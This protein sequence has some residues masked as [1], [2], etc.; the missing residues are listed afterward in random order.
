[1]NRIFSGDWRDSD[2]KKVT[3]FDW[4]NGHPSLME[5]WNYIIYCSL[6]NTSQ[7][8]W[9]ESISDHQPVICLQQLTGTK[10]LNLYDL[11]SRL[12]FYF[13]LSIKRIKDQ[14]LTQ[15]YQPRRN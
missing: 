15:T 14:Q 6:Q 7:C 1:M 3:Y 8:K 11:S 12:D 2:G 5:G 4:E 10:V 9:Q 13:N